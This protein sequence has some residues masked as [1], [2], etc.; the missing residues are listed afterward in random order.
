MKLHPTAK[1]KYL[2]AQRDTCNFCDT[3]FGI[4]GTVEIQAGSYYILYNKNWQNYPPKIDL[5]G[6]VVEK[7]ATFQR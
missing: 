2:Q 5:H 7:Q 6:H 3:Y 4:R 1:W